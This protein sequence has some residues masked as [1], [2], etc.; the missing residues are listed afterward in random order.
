MSVAVQAGGLPLSTRLVLASVV[1]SDVIVLWAPFIWVKI[2]VQ[3]VCGIE[4]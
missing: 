1:G 2:G 3:E 4:M